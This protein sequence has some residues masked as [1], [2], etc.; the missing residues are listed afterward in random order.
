VLEAETM[1]TVAVDLTPMLPGGE[2]GGAKVLALDLVR[3]LPRLAPR[4]RFLLLT[5]SA[6]HQELGALAGDRVERLHVLQDGSSPA[7]LSGSRAEAL[8]FLPAVLGRAAIARARRLLAHLARP[9]ESGPQLRERGVGLLFCPFT[10]PTYAE[11]GIPVVSILYDLQHVEYPQ[12][13]TPQELAA[14]TIHFQWLRRWS[15]R[16]VCI[17]EHSRRSLLRHLEIPAARTRVIPIAVH[18][19]LRAGSAQAAAVRTRFGLARDYLLYP[20]NAWPHKNHRML[21]A[22]FGL[23]LARQP[24][25]DVDLVLTGAFG[26]AADELAAA[27]GGMGLRSRV[28]WLGFVPDDDLAALY[29][30]CRMVVFPSLYEG[31]GIPVLEAMSFG[32]PVACSAV[33]SVP[34]VGGDA[35]RYF[36]PRRLEEI[37]AAMGE[38][39][40]SPGMAEELGWRGRER[41]ASFRAEA[42]AAAYAAIFDE[43]VREPP[44]T[45]DSVAGVFEDGWTSGTMRLSYAPGAVERTLELEVEAPG[46]VPHASIA[47]RLSQS[48]GRDA[49]RWK[50]RRGDRQTLRVRLPPEAGYLSVVIRPLF[51]PREHGLGEDTR[52]LGCLCRCVRIVEGDCPGPNL[53][54]PGDIARA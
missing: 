8:R 1:T 49:L 14:R 12:F 29:Q 31:F 17:S 53:L 47:I 27:A 30:G 44:A 46:F 16:V 41:A 25:L 21:L 39:L 26:R 35:V 22:A 18:E 4:Y 9:H 50:V 36:D 6:N 24:R 7:L 23:L 52:L 51:R 38:V 3:R 40:G 33:T 15:D 5:S 48:S 13:F 45:R 11:P 20:A 43:L 54:A 34:E 19:R 10:A 42:V 2:N 28:R 37:A 32:K